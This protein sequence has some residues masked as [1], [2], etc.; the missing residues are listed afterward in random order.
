MP[1]NDFDPNNVS[2][3]FAQL[4]ASFTS[5]SFS[6]DDLSDLNHTPQPTIRPVP[7]MVR[8][9]R[10]RVDLTGVKP[11]IWRR[12][13]LPGDLTVD[14]LHHVLQIAF[15]WTNS[16]LHK[17]RT[18]SNYDGPSFL[19]AFDISEGDD[20]V[21]E[22]EVRLDQILAEAGDRLWYEYDFGD[23]WHHVLK[24]EKILDDPPVHPVCL[25]GRLAGPPEDC[26]GI[27]GYS[28]IAEWV[29]SGYSDD[30]RPEIFADTA[31][32]RAW[33]PPD[34]DP[35]EFDRDALNMVLSSVDFGQGSGGGVAAEVGAAP[36]AAR[37]LGPATGVPAELAA[38]IE[39]ERTRGGTGLQTA[40][41]HP[42]TRSLKEVTAEE[43]ASATESYRIL[44]EVIGDGTDLTGAGHLKPAVVE[45]IARRTGIAK[46]WIGKAN[47]E[48]QTAPV[49][50]LRDTAKAVGL[51]AVRKK[52]LVPTR[53]AKSL[54]DRPGQLLDHIAGRLPLGRSNW[55]RESGWAAVAVVGSSEPS[56]QWRGRI[57][58]V[59]FGLG[60]RS[61]HDGR[62]PLPVASPTYDVLRMLAGEARSRALPS[63]PVA[64]AV[65]R[66]VLGAS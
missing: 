48:D 29:R 44:L 36:G 24:V 35:D 21:A 22:D 53:T 55:D 49:A 3:L 46:W 5:G 64:A 51:I 65:A 33:L 6:D 12:L 42:A 54:A 63:A 57:T 41:A 50:I 60:W 16:H 13:D 23:S 62:G 58:E 20:G 34:W 2:Q 11:P 26:G 10:V 43:A 9:F 52:R 47:R 40:L 45:E 18:S 7:Q 19:T 17:F 8:G 14:G 38:L 27:W 61:G 32:A 15:A 31:E 28:E 39:Q 59:L 37:G 25:A 56:E 4:R 66:A 30:L 1:T